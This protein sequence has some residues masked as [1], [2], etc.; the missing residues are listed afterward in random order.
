[1]YKKIER[2]L[3]RELESKK[4]RYAVYPFGRGGLLAKEILNVKFGI[5]EEIVVDN[6]L[7]QEVEGILSF[8]QVQNPENYIWI[9]S[10][11]D[12]SVHDE[13]MA[14]VNN[15][16]TD[17]KIIDLYMGENEEIFQ[18]GKFKLLSQLNAE[19]RSKEGVSQACREV[20]E[21]VKK[22]KKERRKIAVAEIG[23]AIG[24]TAVE[25]C[26]M[27]ESNDDYYAFDFHSIANDLIED[28]SKLPEVVCNLHAKGNTDKTYDSYNWTLSEMLFEMRNNE[29]NGMFD[30]VYIDAVH[31]FAHD[32]LA[33]CILKEMIKPGGFMIFDDLNWTFG[34]NASCNPIAF[35]KV[36]EWYTEEQIYDYQIQRVINVF[37]INDKNWQQ[38]YLNS[39]I[40]P[41]RAVFMRLR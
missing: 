34:N 14:T 22:K 4:G 3:E 16:I 8:E 40:N 27:L 9:I 20:T 35:P 31:S 29:Q 21:I 38:I 2:K 41:N 15:R 32:G 26:R 11:M 23:V 6:F 28:L 13:I 30:V 5:C 36:K 17:N 19:D 1:M 33:C 12:K 24:A 10:C 37:M 25:V 18:A 39:D 7:A